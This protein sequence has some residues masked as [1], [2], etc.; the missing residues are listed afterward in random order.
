MAKGGRGTS[1]LGEGVGADMLLARAEHV[2]ARLAS[3]IHGRPARVEWR[4]PG[5]VAAGDTES[6]SSGDRERRGRILGAGVS[7]MVCRD[8]GRAGALT[9][10]LLTVRSRKFHDQCRFRLQSSDHTPVC[11]LDLRIAA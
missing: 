8:L 2:P 6:F 11:I 4:Q 3:A 7:R 1:Q 5:L 10:K 9:E